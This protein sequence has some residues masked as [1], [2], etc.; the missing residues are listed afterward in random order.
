MNDEEIDAALLKLRKLVM[1]KIRCNQC[2][3]TFRRE[4]RPRG[5]NYRCPDCNRPFWAV[6]PGEGKP[7]IC[8][9]SDRQAAEW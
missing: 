8:G 1:G 5:N 9:I 3:M 7:T 6:N 4:D 2:T